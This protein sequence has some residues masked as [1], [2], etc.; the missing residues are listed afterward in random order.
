M[1]L[2]KI[3]VPIDFTVNTHIAVKKAVEL[4]CHDELSVYLLHIMNAVSGSRATAGMQDPSIDQAER[5][6]REISR[7]QKLRSDIYKNTLTNASIET[8]LVE[9]DIE[10]TIVKKAKALEIDLIILGQANEQKVFSLLNMTSPGR[11]ATLTSCPVLKVNPGVKDRSIRLIIVPVEE[12]VPVRKLE[13]AATLARTQSARIHLVTS[14]VSNNQFIDPSHAVLK[15]FETLQ[16]FGCT[17]AIEHKSLEGDNL[18][19]ASLKYAEAMDAD[20]ILVNPDSQ[21]SIA[22]ITG[23]EITDRIMKSSSVQVLQVPPYVMGD[24]ELNEFSKRAI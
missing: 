2:R 24:F 4:S 8:M 13:V 11:I 10:D 12:L 18:P 9:G 1:E 21:K 23:Q 20:L 17:A 22:S 5:Y 3:L 14:S 7:L 15:A 6:Q 16:T 19:I